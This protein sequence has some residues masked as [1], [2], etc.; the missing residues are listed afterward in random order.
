MANRQDAA[1]P[2][3]KLRA[4]RHSILSKETERATG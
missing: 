2:Q 1:T 4:G 3:E